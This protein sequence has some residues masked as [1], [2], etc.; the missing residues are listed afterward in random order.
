MPAGNPDSQARTA[1]MHAMAESLLERLG[2]VSD[3]RERNH[4]FLI[5]LSL[6]N[7]GPMVVW[8]KCAY[9]PEHGLGCAAMLTFPKG[10]VMETE[11]DAVQFVQEV[12]ERTAARGA[13]HLLLL[14]GDV[15]A[16]IPTAAYL[17]PIDQLAAYVRE[18]LATEGGYRIW[19]GSSLDLWVKADPGTKVESVVAVLKRMAVDV[20]RVPPTW[21]PR[22]DAIND[23]DSPPPGNPNPTQISRTTST[24]LRDWKVRSHVI[25][26]SG[27]CCELCDQPGFLMQNGDRYLEAHHLIALAND[28]ADTP[29]NVIAL[30]P[31]HHREAH[32]GSAREALEIEMASRLQ[33]LLTRIVP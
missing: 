9:K 22:L 18:G 15:A 3:A 27:G 16:E 19:N 8:V 30:C 12:A 10:R 14:A 5:E 4:N 33:G 11:E 1:R 13:T 7:V 31:G 2:P 21:I 17:L 23:L 6:P 29:Q 24:Y 28:G 26:R 20:L 25:K 32:Y